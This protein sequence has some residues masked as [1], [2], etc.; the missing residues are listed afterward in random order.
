MTDGIV[1]FSPVPKSVQLN[2]YIPQIEFG[3][4]RRIVSEKGRYFGVKT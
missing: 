3:P 1:D 4:V 2:I